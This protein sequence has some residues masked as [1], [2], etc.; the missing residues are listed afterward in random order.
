MFGSQFERAC[1]PPYG[2]SIAMKFANLID[3]ALTTD[4][5]APSPWVFSPLLCSMNTVNAA[6]T[7][8]PIVGAAPSIKV[9]LPKH[10]DEK[11]LFINGPDPGY[12]EPPTKKSVSSSKSSLVDP[13]TILTMLEPWIWKGGER[14]LTEDSTLIQGEKHSYSK[15]S[16]AERRKHYQKQKAR[17]ETIFNPNIIYN[18][19]VP[20]TLIPDLRPIHQS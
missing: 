3:P 12:V 4:V 10:G 18:F 11:P 16:W 17:K 6:K 20:E 14:E 1:T 15:D 7:S 13:V 8:K 5:F 2:T 19:E 9:E